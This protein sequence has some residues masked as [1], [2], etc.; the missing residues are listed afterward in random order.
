MIKS[1][2]AD[3]PLSNAG[4][5]P[6]YLPDSDVRLI[7]ND[8]D[9]LLFTPEWLSELVLVEV[10]AETATPEGTL[11]S[12]I[13]VLDHLAAL[14]VNGIWLTPIYEKGP[15]GNGYGNR[16]LHTLEP[17]L[18]G[19]DDTASGW[20]KVKE[21]IDA[22]HSRNIRVLL[23]IITWG[24]VFSAPLR[25][26]YPDWFKGEAWGGAAFNW[27][28][29]E[30]REWFTLN[31]VNNILVTGAD[32]YRCDCEPGFAG[33]LI[34]ADIRTRLLALGRKIVI[35]AEESSERRGSFDCEQDGVTGWVD[36]WNRGA[37]YK[38]P[39]AYYIDECDIVDT[40]RSGKLHGSPAS[41][42]EGRSGRD[43]FYTYCVSNHDFQR[44]ITNINRLVIGYQAIFAPYIP[45]WY[46]GAEIGMYAENKVIYFV[47]V[48]WSL[49]ER[50]ECRE[51]CE[52]VARYLRIR[53]TY[54]EIFTEFPFDH[55]ESN[56]TPVEADTIL[57]SYARFAGGKAIIIVPRKDDTADRFEVC[58]D[59][60]ETGLSNVS[61]ITDLMTGK[62]LT[63]DS[64]DCNI[65]FTAREIA[66]NSLGLYLIS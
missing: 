45:L 6:K 58:V 41:Q 28:N 53:R 64:D 15:D 20:Q 4:L 36:G 19:T 55:R 39:K 17:A 60:K 23:D 56:I 25:K 32:G 22:A 18:T 54:P 44:S 8:S 50:L 40:I 2:L 16:G 13:P 26:E 49:I 27:Q 29:E 42:R 46:L 24:T 38:N 33:Y 3:S 21:F 7:P 35:I 14:G 65:R 59:R 11:D 10:H 52:D 9:G 66:V 43:R 5:L 63:F 12:L 34:F 62:E 61:S 31:A 37:Q 48:D 30:F 1:F 57:R 47:P 51:F